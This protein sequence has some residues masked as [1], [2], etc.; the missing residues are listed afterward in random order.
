MQHVRL[1]CASQ[2]LRAN[3]SAAGMLNA[4][5]LEEA[6][7]STAQASLGSRLAH[8]PAHLLLPRSRAGAILQTSPGMR[9]AQAYAASR[10]RHDEAIKAAN[11]MLD[12]YAGDSLVDSRASAI[13]VGPAKPCVSPAQPP[14]QL[15]APL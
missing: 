6:V 8:S 10:R 14:R 5:E 9:R 3:G 7:N 13:Q 2:A 4:T 11:R 1:S 12:A 15:A